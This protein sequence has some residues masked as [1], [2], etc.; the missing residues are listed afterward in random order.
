MDKTHQIRLATHEKKVCQSM[1]Q[2]LWRDELFFLSERPRNYLLA[3]PVQLIGQWIND[4]YIKYT[5]SSLLDILK[6]RVLV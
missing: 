4:V 5:F 2:S 3:W 1:Y 6:S